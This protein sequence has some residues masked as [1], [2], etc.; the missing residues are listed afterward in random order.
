MEKTRIILASSSKP[1]RDNK[2]CTYQHLTPK[3]REEEEIKP[4]ADLKTLFSGKQFTFLEE[5]KCETF[6]EK[7]DSE[8]V[9]EDYTNQEEQAVGER[10]EPLSFF[11]HWSRPDKANRLHYSFHSSKSREEMERVWPEQRSAMKQL[12]RQSHRHALRTNRQ[13]T[14]PMV[15][16][17]VYTS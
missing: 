14:R 15:G 1:Q 13:T 8:K 17:D 7:E 5:E 9:I 2:P 3:E 6:R 10:G 16:H 11:F 4:I 12:L